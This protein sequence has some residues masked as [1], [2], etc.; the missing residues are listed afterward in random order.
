MTPLSLEGRLGTAREASSAEDKY[1]TSL[2]E[3]ASY[4]DEGTNPDTATS[5]LLNEG[6]ISAELHSRLLR[7]D[8]VHLADECASSETSS[9][10]SFAVQHHGEGAQGPHNEAVITSSSEDSFDDMDEATIARASTRLPAATPGEQPLRPNPNSNH[11][12]AS[13]LCAW[14]VDL[15]YGFAPSP[16]SAEVLRIRELQRPTIVSSMDIAYH[17]IDIQ[18]IPWGEYRSNLTSARTVRE[19]YHQHPQVRLYPPIATAWDIPN[20][21]RYFRFEQT[22]TSQRTWIEHYQLRNLVAITSHSDVHYACRSKVMS[23]NGIFESCIMDL[24]NSITSPHA[25]VDFRITSLAATRNTV[26][27]GGFRGEFALQ[28][29][30]AEYGTEPTVGYVSNDPLAIANHIHT[31]YSRSNGDAQAVLCSNNHEVSTLDCRS[32]SIIART[33]YPEVM[34]CA[35][36]A[37]NGRLRVLTGDLHGA[38]IVD[39]DSGRVLESIDGGS[40]GH[41]FACAWADNDIHVA[42]AGQD[43]QVLVWDARNWSIPLAAIATG[44]THTTSLRFSPI[45][46]GSPVLVSA[47][48]ADAVH[49]IDARDYTSKQTID[50]FGDVAGT[51]I[52]ADG[53]QLIIANGDR[54]LGGLMT[55]GRQ[56]YGS[57]VAS[58]ERRGLSRRSDWLPECELR[59]HPRVRLDAKTRRRR[60]L[61]LNDM[62]I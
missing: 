43:C 59:H 55:F 10:R 45:G 51:A 16:I 3:H 21:E 13:F 14:R 37:P 30:T 11:D 8:L 52:S 25:V 39:A 22:N 4:P 7:Q 23:T 50:F 18:G 19:R 44:S 5:L 26:I 42:T 40:R 54:H 6:R 9:L 20:T 15:E 53:S 12:I 47:Q 34:N 46:G 38:L 28:N 32:G 24:S 33:R 57:I 27:A 35:A 49:I 2:F 48:A 31:A 1:A 36:T 60:E 62:F 58:A 29:L 17:G 61:D 41:G 56:D